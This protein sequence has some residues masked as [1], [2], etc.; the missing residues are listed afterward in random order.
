MP[1]S[2]SLARISASVI[3]R[4]F[5]RSI[6]PRL[7]R[8]IAFEF[9]FVDFCSELIVKLPFAIACTSCGYD[10][11]ITRPRRPNHG[12]IDSVDHTDRE[13][14]RLSMVDFAFLLNMD[15]SLV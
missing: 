15:I 4:S 8:C 2:L 9:F 10:A 5:A 6:R 13:I 3:A 14:P 7:F 11:T 1:A 12:H